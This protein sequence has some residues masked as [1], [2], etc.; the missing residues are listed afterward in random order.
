[1]ST[2]DPIRTIRTSEDGFSRRIFRLNAAPSRTEVVRTVMTPLGSR[3]ATQT[4]VA[5]FA[6]RVVEMRCWMAIGRG[7][8]VCGGRRLSH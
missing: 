8:S 1:M 7:H 2:L 6:K 4:V 5:A 3:V